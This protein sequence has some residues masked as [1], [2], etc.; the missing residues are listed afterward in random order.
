MDS[1]S[2]TPWPIPIS[3]RSERCAASGARPR[4]IGRG[5]RRRVPLGAL[6]ASNW[7]SR[8]SRGEVVTAASRHSTG[9]ESGDKLGDYRRRRDPSI[10]PEPVPPKPVPPKGGRRRGRAAGAK[11]FVIQEH[12][13]RALHWDFR[14]ERDGVLVS[15]AIPKGLPLDKKANHLAVHTEDHPL[16]YASFSGT[17]PEGEYGGGTV[18]I[19]DSGTYDE[20]KWSDR[21]VMV[22]LHGRRIEGTYVLF[23]TKGS[24]LGDGRGGDRSWMIHRMD[25]A[26]AGYRAPPR[27]LR[28]MLATPGTLP[29]EHEGW[30]YEFKWDGIR[31]LMYVDGGR[32]H[33]ASRNGN[34]LTPSFPE[35]RGLGEQLGSHPVV[36]DGEIVA[37]DDDGRP[38]FQLLQPRIHAAGANKVKR[39]A[40]EQPAVYMVFDVLYADGALL[41][42][43]PYAERRRRLEN[44]GLVTKGTGNYALSPQ[45]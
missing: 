31:A 8:P 43:L 45:F 2:G 29:T 18:S 27:D 6:V 40:A 5:T 12:H 34:D 42:D 21:E 17:I 10:T 3:S 37:L 30:A 7:W 14:L 26:P 38:R 41:L 39:L 9:A 35:L 44:L 11:T 25:D 4:R 16:E 20:L 36:L 15:W 28:P 1:R 13:A 24:P 22:V 19:W 33:I 32:V 23:A